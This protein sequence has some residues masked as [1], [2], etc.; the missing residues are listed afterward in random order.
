MP[1]AT[2]TAMLKIGKR[3]YV[4]EFVRGKLFT[5]TLN[6]FANLEQDQLRGDGFEGTT[7]F[8]PP[9]SVLN[10]RVG[11]EW[12]PVNGIVD[13]LRFTA[14]DALNVNV[15]CMYLLSVSAAGIVSLVPEIFSFGDTFAV[16]T[17]P[18]EFLRRVAEAGARAGQ[19][20]NY[21]RVSYID[22]TKHSGSVGPFKKRRSF[23]YQRE[24]R[25]V[26]RPGKGQPFKLDVGDLSDLA[27]A[28][29]MGELNQRFGF[30]PVEP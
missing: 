4:E 8:L 10:V 21:G 11:D 30:G 22:E 6:H 26:M 24:F 2:G 15:F 29:A 1:E 3:C 7:A 27:F 13:P 9:G 20:V 5:Q 17:H 16:V 25:I 18:D 23:E 28:F 12:V 19:E 14:K